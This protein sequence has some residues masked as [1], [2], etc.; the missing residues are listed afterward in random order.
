MLPFARRRAWM[1]LRHSI[2]AGRPRLL[3]WVFLVAIA[4][5][6][7]AAMNSA[8]RE[9]WVEVILNGVPRPDFALLRIDSPGAFYLRA[10]DIQAWHLIIP[11]ANAQPD[12]AETSVRIDNVPGLQARLDPG[13]TQLNIDAIP[14][15][16]SVQVIRGRPRSDDPD[17]ASIAFF[18]D[19][20]LFA[21]GS[22]PGIRDVSGH[23]QIGGSLGRTSLTS[24]WLATYDSAE[25]I[26]GSGSPAPAK[27]RRLD[28]ALLIDWPELTARLNIG[29]STTLPGTLGQAVRFSGMHWATDYATQPGLTPYALPAVSG[30]AAVPSSV[31]LYLNQ[32]LLQ[33]TPINS[34]PFELHNIPVPIGMGDVELHMRDL[35]GRDQVLS[36]P[37]LVS[38]EL[39]SPGVTVSDFS[40]GAIRTNYGVASFDYGSP[41]VSAA[42]RHGLGNGLTYDT[43]AEVQ[44]NQW[45]ARGGIALRLAPNMTGSVTPAISH[46]SAGTGTAVDASLD[47]VS[48]IGQFGVHLR[49]A[50]RDFVELGSNV[51]P[52][53]LHMQWAAQAS[54]QLSRFGSL[55]VTYARQTAYNG[56]TT[57]ATTLSYN[58]TLSRSTAIS[59]F[60][61]R[62]QSSYN[63]LI[64]G[65]MFTRFL[66]GNT[67]ASVDMTS[68]NGA[69]TAVARVSAAAPLDAGWG[70]DAAI[71]RGATDSNG[72][73]IQQ[74]SAFGIASAEIDATSRSKTAL[75]GWQGGIL[76]SADRPWLGQPLSGPAAVV[77]L[78]DLAGV[79]ILRD[80][81]PAGRTDEQGRILVVGL[82][83]F[84][85]NVI[86]YVPE[87]LPLTALVTGGSLILRPYSRGVVHAQFPV[88]AAASE[89]IELQLDNSQP[90]PA[91]AL[92]TLNG[93]DFPVGKQGLVQIPVLKHSLEAVVT[94]A[95]GR[96]RMRLPASHEHVAMRAIRCAPIP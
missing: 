45:A 1:D 24:S 72:I 28:S 57:A 29:D 9:L 65:L 40:A 81:Q 61:S 93:H 34:G 75:L 25:G 14:G 91:G 43:S 35:L 50:S 88:A 13:E 64:V 19:Y 73:R 69:A 16:F 46:S 30:T 68:D 67:S 17:P 90:V 7:V 21:Q 22:D 82:R 87:D 39:I 94:W 80:G 4:H 37:Y 54:R 78:P 77:E 58:A 32:S 31:E 76:W 41:F 5:R 38:P 83:P 59:S 84:E 47:S 96:C 44:P 79:R 66:G 55:A 27:W 33:R 20:D 52:N 74:R 26:R 2:P 3:V 6:P 60:A 95:G 62:T 11:G 36:V 8:G 12:A 53:H 23:I 48:R 10:S 89:A 85:E 42:I 15:L 63:D 49:A 71:S 86:S 56:E 70:W 51:R 18:S 92:L